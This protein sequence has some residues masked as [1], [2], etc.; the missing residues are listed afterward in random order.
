MGKLQKHIDDLDNEVIRLQMAP[1]RSQRSETTRNHEL[2]RT[3]VTNLRVYHSSPATS[4]NQQQ[5]AGVNV[6]LIEREAAE[7]SENDTANNRSSVSP[8]YPQQSHSKQGQATVNPN[9]APLHGVKSSNPTQPVPLDLLL[10][11]SDKH[12]GKTYCLA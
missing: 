1:I 11:A 3:T 6:T 8:N 4:P 9:H 2:L 12:A 10:S 5:R 7:G